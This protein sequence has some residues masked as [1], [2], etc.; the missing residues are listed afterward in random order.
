MQLRPEGFETYEHFYETGA[1]A[2]SSGELRTVQ[3]IVN[4]NRQKFDKNRE[5]LDAAWSVLQSVG[6]LEDAW[7]QVAPQTEEERLLAMAEKQHDEDDDEVME[8][9]VPDLGTDQAEQQNVTSLC[10]VE[11]IGDSIRPLLKTMNPKQQD[12][13]YHVR[14]HCVERKLNEKTKPIHLHISGGAGVGKSHLIKCIYNEASRILRNGES[15]SDTTVLLAAPTGT[16]AFNVGGYTIH[17]A[18][19]IPRDLKAHYE[20]LSFETANSLRAS[21]GNLKLLIIDEISMVDRRVLSYIHGRLNQIKHIKSTQRDV[22]FGNVSILALGDF[23]QLPPVKA[24]SLMTPDTRQGFDLWHD[25]FSVCTLDEIMRQKDD[26][27]FA[28]MLNR[29]RVK[30]K[31]EELCEEDD[32]I[33]RNRSDLPDIP[34]TALHVFATNKLAKNHNEKILS[35]ISTTPRT[36]KAKDYRKDVESRTVTECSCT[37]A[38]DDLLDEINVDISARVMLIRN[39][40]VKDGLVNG[41]FGNVVGFE[42]ENPDE[43]TKVVYIKFDSEKSGK[44]MKDKVPKNS[45]YHGAVPVTVSEEAM[46]KTKHVSRRQFPFKLAWA[47]T[48]HKTQGMTVDE[49]VFDMKAVFASGQSYVALSRVTSLNG[50]YIKNYDKMKI[51]RSD[52]VHK[53]ITKMTPLFGNENQTAEN[54]KLKVVHHN[55]QG[56]R[57]KL[58]DIKNHKKIKSDVMM[59]SETLLTTNVPNSMLE[60]EGYNIYRQERAGNTG[61]GG[62]VTYAKSELNVERVHFDVPEIENLAVKMSHEKET[63]LV[64]MYRSPK[65]SVADFCKALNS[66]LITLEVTHESA[67]KIIAGDLNEDLFSVAPKQIQ[68][69]FFNNGYTQQVQ[70]ATTLN[71][72]LIDVVYTKISNTCKCNVVPTYYSDHEAVELIVLNTTDENAY[73][74]SNIAQVEEV[75][76]D[77]QCP[78]SKQSSQPVNDDSFPR[79]ENINMYE[80]TTQ[81]KE[82]AKK[83]NQNPEK[84]PRKIC[85]KRKQETS[86][87]QTDTA[88][89]RKNTNE[90]T[91]HQIMKHHVTRFTKRGLSNLGNTCFANTVFQMLFSLESFEP[92]L[93][94]QGNLGKLLKRMDDRMHLERSDEPLNLKQLFRHSDMQR[95]PVNQQQD[96]HE[97]LMWILRKL[98]EEQNQNDTAVLELVGSQATTTF[99]CP[100]CSHAWSSTEEMWSF[101]LPIQNG[102]FDLEPTGQNSGRPCPNCQSPRSTCSM[103]LILCPQILILH[104]MRFDRNQ[105]KLQTPIKL[106]EAITTKNG[107]QYVLKAVVNH[108]GDSVQRGHYTVCI[109]DQR[110]QWSSCD[111]RNVRR[112]NFQTISK[113]AYILI[114][115]QV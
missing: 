2:L 60:L 80:N 31:E 59:F 53:N 46:S 11:L 10:S 32:E 20:P 98:H 23:Y 67:E 61:R 107:T 70:H 38:S 34:E 100:S 85:V 110:G 58:Q 7:A 17:S 14:Q 114:Y 18:L 37:G 97:F 51:F 1:V 86:S 15:P 71:G 45:P 26:A 78:K 49:C 56:L 89:K 104:I 9:D 106:E 25:L 43:D 72:T 101:S 84:L 8:D 109:R 42:P 4:E 102:N 94:E 75:P 82:N 13:F 66:F 99:H 95:W 79:S 36:L 6:L 29:L 90:D 21:L 5:E 33:L 55:V 83:T 105:K 108:V 81:S 113:T 73:C 103:Q 63:I 68:R 16:A 39:I 40:D 64:N 76:Q 27:P 50:L 112:I 115:D 12:V 92:V 96:A 52:D 41:A 69:T 22:W 44:S 87:G 3:D 28:E 65:K 57:S 88:K 48:I 111:D 19:K 47:C 74:S 30:A 91:S 93:C 35:K 77:R 62:L 54:A 24:K